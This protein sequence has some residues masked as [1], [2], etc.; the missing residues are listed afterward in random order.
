MLRTQH[1]M[2]LY[3]LHHFNTAHNIPYS[4]HFSVS[5]FNQCNELSHF[6]LKPQQL[7]IHRLRLQAQHNYDADEF[8]QIIIPV[9]RRMLVMSQQ[10]PVTR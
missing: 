2:F 8:A 3:T 7:M 6:L 9:P 1:F 10:T 4:L 5:A